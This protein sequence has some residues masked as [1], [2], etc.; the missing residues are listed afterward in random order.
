MT[1]KSICIFIFVCLYMRPIE[2]LY[3]AIA[4][5]KITHLDR[6]RFTHSRLHTNTD[7]ISVDSIDRND[8]KYIIPTY[9][10][11]M[12]FSSAAAATWL[13]QPVLSLID[14]ACIGMSSNNIN[15]VAQLAAVGP[16]I[17]WIDS[18]SYL[19]SFLG[20]ATTNLFA[21]ALADKNVEEQKTIT[22]HSL[23]ISLYIG[24]L[25]N[26]AQYTLAPI[27]MRTLSGTAV[28]SIPYAIE[29]CRYR[30][31]ASPIAVPTMILQSILMASRDSFTPLKAVCVGAVANII[32]D[33]LLVTVLKYGSTG[34]AIATTIAQ[35]IG[36]AFL[37]TQ[38]IL[39]VKKK[40]ASKIS[41]TITSRS[42]TGITVSTASFIRESIKVP[43]L[44]D[45]S[46]FLSF[47]GPLFIILFF[48]SFLWSYTTYS[49]AA[50]GTVQLAA[51]QI[52]INIYLFF[53]I[54]GDVFSQSS[55]TYIPS[56]LSGSNPSKVAITACSLLLKKIG[57][58][59]IVCGTVNTIISA[60][61]QV[62][63]NNLFTK[64]IDII[65]KMRS[66][67]PFLGLSI[68]PHS[69]MA[70]Y[71]GSMIATRDINFHLGSYIATGSLFIIAMNAI[72][73]RRLGIE[74]VW[75]SMALF[76][77]I[78]LGL[79]GFRVSHKLKQR[80]ASAPMSTSMTIG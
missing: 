61:L 42:T 5:K 33:Y 20:V 8:N 78:R 34:A 71:E 56:Y 30:S 36:F 15:T 18:S 46:K 10:D 45:I 69:L 17:A 4:A 13:L 21:T 53:V 16:G 44:K 67:A 31:F 76:Q 22:S 28:N 75:L 59:T 80:M 39:K 29:Y 41:A 32:G 57:K 49:V 12:K 64:N 11:L 73:A 52:S 50:A 3:S 7:S 68:L 54:F 6:G 62:Y 9:K 23:F 25:L 79:F 40:H 43:R 55:Q 14:T 19:A 63:G 47:S 24:I 72:K 77:W 37:V 60:L 66:A 27:L 58:A 65:N 26:V 2:S 74:A 48:K 51:H 35:Y 1:V 38:S 70:M